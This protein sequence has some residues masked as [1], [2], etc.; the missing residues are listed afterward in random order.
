MIEKNI[1]AAAG[2]QPLSETVQPAGW[3]RALPRPQYKSYEQIRLEDEDWYEI[4]RVAPDTYALYE[5]G[6][7]Q[8]VISF[9]II[10]RKRALVWD[11][12]MGIQPLRPVLKR[13]TNLPLLA[14]NSHN[15]FDHVGGNW[16]FPL[17]YGFE[18]TGSRQR[19]AQGYS[20][21]FLAPMMG[22]DSLSRPL[23]KGFQTSDYALRPWRFASLQEEKEKL[24]AGLPSPFS[25]SSLSALTE[26][27]PTVLP[28]FLGLSLDL[29]ER[30]LELLHTPG[31][32][33]DSIMLWDQRQKILFT[34]DTVYPAA[35]Y[36]HFDD[37]EYGQSSLNIYAKT[38]HDL[39]TL[40][41][42][43]KSL[44]CSHNF[45]LNPPEL[46]KKVSDAFFFLK[47]GA[48]AGEPDGEGNL[49]QNFDGFSIIYPAKNF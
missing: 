19:A 20:H 1:P 48:S 4:Y 21:E 22:A 35:L 23:P 49:R 13:L 40:I 17:V 41:P 30:R 44:C 15:H 8:E 29:G 45:P 11:T 2:Y 43:L 42:S 16:E 26:L 6:H 34:G 14:L 12:G 24:T 25:L 18:S 3:Q 39:Q 46:L 36:A 5:P 27:A 38:M 33:A 28:Y 7:F 9:L 31:H 37:A 10:G 32:T 47:T